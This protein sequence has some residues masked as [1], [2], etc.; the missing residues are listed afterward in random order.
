[1]NTSLAKYLS[2]I[3]LGVPFSTL[4][5]AA[6]L[7]RGS[8]ITRPTSFLGQWETAMSLK[9]FLITRWYWILAHQVTALVLSW[10]VHPFAGLIFLFGMEVGQAKDDVPG[11][12][13]SLKKWD[14]MAAY[15]L[16]EIE[17]IQWLAPGLIS[18]VI[19]GIL[20]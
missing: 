5:P 16:T 12:L 8:H 17:L 18:A 6:H 15:L 11:S 1:M 20:V 19:F 14:M 9:E 13:K 10:A 4:E 3:H 2:T 7:G